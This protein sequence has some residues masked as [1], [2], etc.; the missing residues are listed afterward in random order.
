MV[1]LVV[2]LLGL[3]VGN[4]L[5]HYNRSFGGWISKHIVQFDD[6]GTAVERL[7]NFGLTVNFFGADWLEN[8][9]DTRLVV[10]GIYT[11]EHF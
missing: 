1:K 6:I 9:N 5:K 4:V 10:L 3:D 8:L 11:L 2:Q 7:Q